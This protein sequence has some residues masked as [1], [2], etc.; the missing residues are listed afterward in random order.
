MDA[1]MSLQIFGGLIYLLL[2]G[3]L[4]VRGA[5]SLARKAN[6][7]PML[8]G[9][10]IVAIG[11]SAPELFTSVQAAFQGYGG[12]ALGN[13]V[14]SNIANVFL[15]VGAPALIYPMMCDRPS[16]RGDGSVMVATSALLF[17]LCALGPLGRVDGGILLLGLGLFLFLSLR[18][19]ETLSDRDRE[20]ASDLRLSLGLPSGKRMIVLFLVLG[21]IFLPLGASLLLDGAVGVATALGVSDA[22]IGLTL[23]ALGTSLP[24]LATTLVAAWRHQSDVALG[25]VLGSNVMNILVVLGLTALLSPEPIEVPR[26]FLVLDLP[27]MMSGAMIL[28]YFAWQCRPIRRGPGIIMVSAYVLYVVLLFSA[29]ATTG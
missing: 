21:V 6:L 4:L 3:D 12:I 11:T 14:G 19:P 18:K 24:E 10:T 8:V 13:V 5:V 17:L 7:S 25:N 9:L 27:I 22:V 26:S 28:L 1:L 23:V 15:V 16:A 20:Q 29:G 2:G